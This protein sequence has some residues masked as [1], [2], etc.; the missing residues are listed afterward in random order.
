MY[1]GA[2]LRLNKYMSMTRFE[3]ILFSLRY[4]DR[5]VVEYNYMLF[6]MRQ[7]EESWSINVAEELNPSWINVTDESMV[8]WFN[9]CVPIF[10]CVGRE[11][12]TFSD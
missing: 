6:H 5:K 9:K 7:M 4:K 1:V 11:S 2:A 8:N 10:M 12:H 3:G